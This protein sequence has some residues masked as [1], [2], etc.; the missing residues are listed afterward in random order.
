MVTM[1]YVPIPFPIEVKRPGH[2]PPQSPHIAPVQGPS[3]AAR[4]YAD[5]RP[6]QALECASV[7]TTLNVISFTYTGDG[8]SPYSKSLEPRI[9]VPRTSLC[10]TEKFCR[11]LMQSNKSKIKKITSIPLQASDVA[12]SKIESRVP[13]FRHWPELAPRTC[14]QWQSNTALQIRRPSSWKVA[15]IF[16][17]AI[18]L[19]PYP[20][21]TI[22][23][24][25][26]TSRQDGEM[27]RN[28]A[29]RKS[30]PQRGGHVPKI[31]RVPWTI[32]QESSV[33]IEYV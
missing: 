12:F 18:P 25:A 29:L 10:A 22:P 14:P 17:I 3:A 6:Q 11:S 30:E 15:P 19:Q 9:A 23:H 13:I 4:E 5:R 31:R 8:G 1:R 28:E 20:Y 16:V 26:M 27:C 21:D 2:R 32:I 7:G 33:V 24:A